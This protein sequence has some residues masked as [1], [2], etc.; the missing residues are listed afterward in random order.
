MMGDTILFTFLVFGFVIFLIY[1]L[2][3]GNKL[4]RKK[5]FIPLIFILLAIITVYF[6]TGFKK[7]NSDISRI[8]HN[9]R[10]K[11]PT[12]V[13]TVL[14]KTPLDSG[15]TIVNLK[16]QVIPV[17]DCCIWMEVKISPNELNRIANLKKYAISVYS[18]SDS[19]TFLREFGD[20]PT[21]WTPQHLGD[22]L[23]KL[24]I[25]FSQENQQSIFFGADSS[26]A[27]ICDQAL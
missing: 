19:L 1:G 4:S 20:R 14:F 13:Y 24:S 2:I 8:I 6:Y 5:F 15:M 16:D 10:P 27:Y 21:W 17:V 22:S 3:R 23:T 11:S 26:H 12:E 7:I 18:R 25:I 9:S